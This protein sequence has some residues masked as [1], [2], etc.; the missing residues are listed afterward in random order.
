M[1]VRSNSELAGPIDSAHDWAFWE[2]ADVPLGDQRL[3]RDW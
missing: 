1:D 3:K 2:F